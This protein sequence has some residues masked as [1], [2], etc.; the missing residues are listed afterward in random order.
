VAKREHHGPRCEC[1]PCL[2]KR[3]GEFE[4]RVRA[5]NVPRMPD[6]LDQCIPVRAHWRRSRNYLK[7]SP[8]LRELVLDIVRGLVKEQREE[9]AA[10]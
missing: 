5:M 8:K 9:R 1:H 10:R 4:M 6:G 7:H 3:L 2:K